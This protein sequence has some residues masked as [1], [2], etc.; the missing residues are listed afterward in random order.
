MIWDTVLDDKT[1]RKCNSTTMSYFVKL[2]DW[3]NEKDAKTTNQNDAFLNPE[4]IIQ[5]KAANQQLKVSPMSNLPNLPLI[6][7]NNQRCVP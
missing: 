3:C 6:N 4:E 1:S 2:R 7:Q 5:S